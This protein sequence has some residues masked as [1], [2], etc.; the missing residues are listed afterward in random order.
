MLSQA[1]LFY[2][3]ATPQQ[4]HL[5]VRLPREGIADGAT[6]RGWVTGPECEVAATLPSRA[7]LRDMGAGETLLARAVLPDP[8]FWSARLPARYRVSIELCQGQQV[9]ASEERLVGIRALGIVKSDL[10]QEGK[11]IVLRMVHRGE[12]PS[13]AVDSWR[14]HEAGMFAVAP[15]DELCEE[16]S[17]IGVAITAL[18]QGN[19]AEV[20]AQLRNLARHAAVSIAVVDG[21]FD[22]PAE[23]LGDAAPNILLFQ[24]VSP[25]EQRW[26]P[27]A[28][29]QG[30]MAGIVESTQFALA[31]D[32]CELPILAAR[33]HG[34]T[35]DL[36]AARTA[37]DALQRD[38]APYCQCAG[39]IV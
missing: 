29:A 19:A 3:T 34:P 7:E 5:Y 13:L 15:S 26:Q 23:Q 36:A 12:A 4:A 21:N 32:G 38:L 22:T 8:V 25:N 27:A 11:R 20:A 16:A 14:E 9:L 18:V 1:D 10:R 37:C 2:G 31:A 28:W 30:I 33:P 39:Y 17:R 35:D 6:L 24:P